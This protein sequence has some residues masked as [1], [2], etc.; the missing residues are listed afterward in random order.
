[1]TAHLKTERDDALLLIC[2][3]Q[4]SQSFSRSD[5]VQSGIGTNVWRNLSFLWADGSSR[6][7]QN[8]HP[9]NQLHCL[10]PVQS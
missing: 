4:H 6:V 2:D 8:R 9:L 5:V 3:L 10:T 1:M 7:L